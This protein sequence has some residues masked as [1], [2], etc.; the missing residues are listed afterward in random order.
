LTGV[1]GWLRYASG[2]GTERNQH[3]AAGALAYARRCSGVAATVYPTHSTCLHIVENMTSSTKPK[4][5]TYRFAARKRPS[6]GTGNMRKNLVKFRG[7]VP[8]ICLWTDRQTDR[9]TDTLITML[10]S[11]TGQSNEIIYILT[12]VLLGCVA[13]RPVI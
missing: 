8:G 7:M 5:I 11:P 4:D 3:Q 9:P 1:P 12:I 13:S 10:R 6:Y 2:H